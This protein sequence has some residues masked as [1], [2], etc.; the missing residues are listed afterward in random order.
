MVAQAEACDLNLS[1]S[2]SWKQVVTV[3]TFIQTF[4]TANLME[5]SST[6]AGQVAV[7]AGELL[8][9]AVKYAQGDRVEV[10]LRL[11][12]ASPPEL[13]LTVENDATEQS[14]ASVHA[15]YDQAMAGDALETYL[16]M[17][18]D[19]VLRN[20]GHSRLGL[21][22]IRNESG[23]RLLLDTSGNRVRFTLEN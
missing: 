12:T 15:L 7:A 18:R 5:G 1:F 14:I 22:R 3:R 11:S 21:V 19:S 16:Q 20:D 2:R 6:D 8:E 17:M 10:R 9:N 13:Q 23:C 4:L